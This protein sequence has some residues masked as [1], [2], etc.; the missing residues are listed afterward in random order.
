MKS[1]EVY[2]GKIK[3]KDRFISL[4]YIRSYYMDIVLNELSY[5]CILDE[6]EGEWKKNDPK[7]FC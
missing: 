1:N 4:E 3:V 5:I 7:R 2:K 6:K